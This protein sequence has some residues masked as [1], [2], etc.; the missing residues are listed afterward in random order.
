MVPLEDAFS[1]KFL[2]GNKFEY[3]DAHRMIKKYYKLQ[4][5]A[6]ELF[7]QIENYRPVFE[8]NTLVM[9]PEIRTSTNEGIIVCTP[10]RWDPDSFDFDTI[11]GAFILITE[12]ALLHQ[13]N[14]ITGVVVIIDMS[15][16]TWNQVKNF[17]P[18]Q[19]KKV[20]NV[21]EDC[22]PIR[23]VKI[24]VI[25]KSQI[26]RMSLQ[27]IKPFVN[28]D[29]STRTKLFSD[30]ESFHDVI[31]P[32]R[33]PAEL[34]GN[35]GTMRGLELYQDLV[36]NR[37]PITRYWTSSGFGVLPSGDDDEDETSPDVTQIFDDL[38]GK[39]SSIMKNF[40]ANVKKDELMENFAK[41][42]TNCITNFQSFFK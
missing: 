25:N 33:L 23:V 40:S 38:E 2:R 19:A 31:S 21:V 6:P 20:V 29:I 26:A 32:D 35:R 42:H 5:N 24:Y 1:I 18:I 22:L 41:I 17:G 34:G 15:N 9:L 4:S 36:S 3:E 8:S 7:A 28:E 37:S 13:V 30:M 11:L 39:A 14:Q 10:S 16:L 27:V 12:Y